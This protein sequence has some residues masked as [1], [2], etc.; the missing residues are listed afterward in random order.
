MPNLSAR[1]KKL[2]KAMITGVVPVIKQEKKGEIEIKSF[3]FFAKA[4]PEV[5][6]KKSTLRAKRSHLLNFE[7]W[8]DDH[9]PSA[10]RAGERKIGRETLQTYGLYLANE[11][12][13]RQSV[14][15]YA[16]TVKTY[17][18]DA[19]LVA[20]SILLDVKLKRA[21]KLWKLACLK[22]EVSKAELML[23]TDLQK[24]QT[25]NDRNCIRWW[26]TNG[27]R[28]SS[29][30]SV[31]CTFVSETEK[32]SED[33][34]RRKPWKSTSV[35]IPNY[36]YLDAGVSNS[37]EIRCG[38]KRGLG[39]LFA[40][41]DEW[42]IYHCDEA[43]MPSLPIG[44]AKGK[45]LMKDLGLSGHSIRR[46]LATVIR[47]RAEA[48]GVMGPA[49]ERKVNAVFKWGRRSSLLK[50]YTPDWKEAKKLELPPM[51]DE[52]WKYLVSST[53]KEVRNKLMLNMKKF[54]RMYREDDLVVGRVDDK[55]EMMKIHSREW[56]F[57]EWANL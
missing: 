24:A 51:S 44:E 8:L 7:E 54:K 36:K 18:I 21:A 50:Y 39:P 57:S 42:C 13:R 2:K 5:A 40:D 52:L 17:F 11:G 53:E 34:P 12:F 43:Q 16:G 49:F 47:I 55:K 4:F 33:A 41:N 27:L 19:D 22:H 1:A 45:A 38:C 32:T 20:T 35:W 14:I 31:K 6:Y 56:N 10:E 3:P 25:A 26:F 9:D 46:T 28:T 30:G 48:E 23:N 15:D 37:V 29:L